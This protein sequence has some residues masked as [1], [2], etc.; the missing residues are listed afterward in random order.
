MFGGRKINDMLIPYKITM[1][2]IQLN[3]MELEINQS[4]MAY[5]ILNQ[6][7]YELHLRE[8]HISYHV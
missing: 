8:M 1:V 3:D 4:V 2:P 5:H 7:P 6:C